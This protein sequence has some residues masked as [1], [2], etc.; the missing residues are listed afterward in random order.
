MKFSIFLLCISFT[1][2]VIAQENEMPTQISA[3]GFTI[4]SFL[5]SNHK[6]DTLFLKWNKKEEGKLVIMYANSKTEANYKRSYYITDNNNQQLKLNFLSRIVGIAHVMLN[7][8]FTQSKSGNIYNLYCTYSS[9][10]NSDVKHY[11]LCKIK[12]K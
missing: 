10:D 1:F 3:Q 8:F 4:K 12:L 2:S 7:D 11:L 9:I 5:N 6:A